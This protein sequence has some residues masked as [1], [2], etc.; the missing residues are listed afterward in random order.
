MNL[1]SILQLCIQIRGQ[2]ENCDVI[3]EYPR[4][5]RFEISTNFKILANACRFLLAFVQ[6]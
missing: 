6:I 1:Y 4:T 2:N 5:L 3:T